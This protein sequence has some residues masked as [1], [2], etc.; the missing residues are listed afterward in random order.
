M[1]P[2]YVVAS[3][4]LRICFFERENF[5]EMIIANAER[6]S[7]KK[8]KKTNQFRDFSYMTLFFRNFLSITSRGVH[9]GIVLYTS[10]I[11]SYTE[12]CTLH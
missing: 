8:Y 9:R 1:R 5:P 10:N 12:E 7:F 11:T 3:T 2:K 6:L 4:D